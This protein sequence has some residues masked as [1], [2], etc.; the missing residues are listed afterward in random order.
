MAFCSF[1]DETW[2]STLRGPFVHQSTIKFMLRSISL[3][4]Y[5][6]LYFFQY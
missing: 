6:D 5:F 1:Y 2:N 4:R 3:G